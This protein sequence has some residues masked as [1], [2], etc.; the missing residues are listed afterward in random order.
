M[1]QHRKSLFFIFRNPETINAVSSN[2]WGRPSYCKDP[3]L[4]LSECRGLDLRM[5]MSSESSSPCWS[6]E[7]ASGGGGMGTGMKGFHV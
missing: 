1:L 7:A 5:L 3:G 6:D 2:C 4:S